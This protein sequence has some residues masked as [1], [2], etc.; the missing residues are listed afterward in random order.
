MTGPPPPTD[1]PPDP[2]PTFRLMADIPSTTE[3]L[4]RVREGPVDPLKAEEEAKGSGRDDEG[5]SLNEGAAWK[6]APAEDKGP[7]PRLLLLTPPPPPPP[8]TPPTVM[9]RGREVGA[10][11]GKEVSSGSNDSKENDPGAKASAAE[12]DFA[13]LI[14]ICCCCCCCKDTGA[15][16]GAGR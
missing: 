1:P 6:V 2:G 4:P 8:P 16:L 7:P 10:G 14:I 5:R 3:L 12:K 13:W 15:I 9:L 11:R